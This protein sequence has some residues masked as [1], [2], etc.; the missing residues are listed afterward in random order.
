MFETFTL[1]G[2]SLEYKSQ[3]NGYINISN[4][5]YVNS[6]LTYLTVNNLVNSLA[7]NNLLQQD[8]CFV[9]DFSL[10]LAFITK[11]GS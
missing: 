5:M 10:S 2:I 9:F 1:D 6:I 3:L 7:M 8:G 4:K 11:L